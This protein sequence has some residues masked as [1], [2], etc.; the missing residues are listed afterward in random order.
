MQLVQICSHQHQLAVW[1]AL[2]KLSK[3]WKCESRELLMIGRLWIEEL[4]LI[5]KNEC[6]NSN[7]G[8]WRY[9]ADN[10]SWW[11][12]IRYLTAFCNSWFVFLITIFRFFVLL[13]FILF[14]RWWSYKLKRGIVYWYFSWYFVNF[15]NNKPLLMLKYKTRSR[16]KYF[17]QFLNERSTMKL[18]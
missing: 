10:V 9:L 17:F 11:N 4:S 16:G 15:I 6:H 8:P 14:W 1:A 2:N 12:S 5:Q 13:H 18:L 7:V 3:L